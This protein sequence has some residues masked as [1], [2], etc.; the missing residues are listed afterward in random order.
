MV[1]V[2]D[3]PV[4]P[5]YPQP[6]IRFDALIV[7]PSA[8]RR[9]TLVEQLHL[10]G[11]HEV[12]EAATGAEAAV[13]ARHDGG[14]DVCLLDGAVADRP[15]LHL[16]NELRRAGW[17][18]VVLMT[19]RRDPAAVRAALAGGIRVFIVLTEDAVPAQA[20]QPVIVRARVRTGAPDELSGRE[21][22]VLQLV[23]EGNSNRDVGDRLRL[24]ALTVKSHLAR[25]A[26]KMGTGDRAEMVALA[27]RSQLIH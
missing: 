8:R 25:I 22:E 2:V 1:A 23:A 14:H 6:R 11:A 4:A 26:R 9:A 17:Q 27:M 20:R 19:S 13:R 10:L 5:A 15:V 12:I 3:R 21:V 7:S 18:R 16:T 24:S